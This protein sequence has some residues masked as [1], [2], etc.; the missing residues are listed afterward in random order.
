MQLHKTFSSSLPTGQGLHSLQLLSM[1]E[2][3][4][5]WHV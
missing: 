2:T 4:L 3:L 5:V 1:W